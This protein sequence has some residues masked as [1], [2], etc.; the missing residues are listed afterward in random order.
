MQ[1][2]LFPLYRSPNQSTHKAGDTGLLVDTFQ[3]YSRGTDRTPDR[4][5]MASHLNQSPPRFYLPSQ[6]RSTRNVSGHCIH[7]PDRR[8]RSITRPPK[9]KPPNRRSRPQ[10]T[11]WIPAT[12]GISEEPA[13]RWAEKRGGR[14]GWRARPRESGRK[15]ALAVMG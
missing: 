11:K 10:L 5:L 13:T 12:S 6:T 8:H 4:P 2:L 15:A 1:K 3:I 14:T 9:R 7:K